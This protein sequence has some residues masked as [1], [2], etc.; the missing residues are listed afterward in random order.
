MSV[1]STQSQEAVCTINKLIGDIVELKRTNAQL[2]IE[3]ERLSGKKK[4]TDCVVEET[5][6]ERLELKLKETQRLLEV[7]QE[8]YQRM[9]EMFEKT[10][11]KYDTPRSSS[12]HSS[13][14]SVST[15]RGKEKEKGKGRSKG[16]FQQRVE[17]PKRKESV[18][19]GTKKL[20]LECV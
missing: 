12:I 3:N 6:V 19:S 7:S 4:Q 5:P 20:G 8:S 2:I 13:V 18:R 17:T 14:S 1:R 10:Q 9:K 15:G 16:R 11:A